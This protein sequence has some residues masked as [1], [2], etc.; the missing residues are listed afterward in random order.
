[1]TIYPI[2]GKSWFAYMKLP[3]LYMLHT[4]GSNG[5][6][7]IDRVGMQLLHIS[8]SSPRSLTIGVKHLRIESL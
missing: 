3:P 6:R 8:E 7:R 2:V 4:N 5:I 1:M